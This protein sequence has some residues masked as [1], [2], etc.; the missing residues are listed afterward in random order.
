ME[1]LDLDIG[2]YDLNDILRLF[3]LTSDFNESDLKKAKQ[4]VLKIHPDKSKL[5]PQYFIF[6]SKAYK[7][8]YNIYEFRNKST[9]KKEE[10]IYIPVS[11][12]E[13]SAALN[14]FI[15]KNNL[16]DKKKFNSWFNEQFEKNKIASE[17]ETNGYGDWLRSDDDIDEDCDNIKSQADM[18]AEF[19]R[20]KQQARSLIVHQDIND[21]Y[22]NM[23]NIGASSLSTDAPG[24]YSSELFSQ[25]SYQDLKLAHTE[26]VIPVT[27]E[28]YNNVRKFN[29]VNEYMSYRS[30][31]DTKPLSEKQ[32]LEYLQNKNKIDD[33]QASK[34]AYEL[35][36]QTEEAE[37]QNKTFWGNIL[38]ITK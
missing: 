12:D 35:A 36:K 15:E 21:M 1:S 19:N 2:N 31:Q 25:L 10:E 22:M 24:E 34:R 29:N 6:Y 17:T 23:N 8:L 28:D 38:R 37:K 3:K 9:N 5:D 27:D 26:S 33:Q 4:I 11:S 18:A 30:N 16:K 7:I 32:A 20:K 13:K 14:V